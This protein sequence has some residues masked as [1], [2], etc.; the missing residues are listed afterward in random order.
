MKLR[1]VKLK[2]HKVLEPS[3]I[4]GLK[5]YIFPAFIDGEGR[6]KGYCVKVEDE[7]AYSQALGFHN[8]HFPDVNQYQIA[9]H[10]C[11]TVWPDVEE[12]TAQAAVRR[13][14]KLPHWTTYAKS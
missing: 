9:K 4:P 8:D 12:K 5:Q 3:Q 11:S 13:W 7:G 10:L 2:P 14:M 1:E 6:N